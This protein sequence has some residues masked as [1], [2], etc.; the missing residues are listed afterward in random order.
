MLAHRVENSL[1]TADP[2]D[3]LADR[4]ESPFVTTGSMLSYSA[5]VIAL[6]RCLSKSSVVVKYI[7]LFALAVEAILLL[8]SRGS[9]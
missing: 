2:Q 1:S 4:V 5:H 6:A 8:A 7:H 9:N 3:I